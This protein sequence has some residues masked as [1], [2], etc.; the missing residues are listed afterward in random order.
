M[1]GPVSCA[2]TSGC[3]ASA[4][5]VSEIAHGGVFSARRPTNPAVSVSTRVRGVNSVIGTIERAMPVAHA[6]ATSSVSG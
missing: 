3:T 2:T 5:S 6:M 4:P 1:F